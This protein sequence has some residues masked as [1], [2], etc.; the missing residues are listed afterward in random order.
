VLKE[1]KEQREPKEL[2]VIWVHR[3]PKVRQRVHKVLKVLRVIE[4]RKVLRVLKDRMV[5]QEELV[6]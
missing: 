3:E 6:D 1:P 5:R 2:R 4:D